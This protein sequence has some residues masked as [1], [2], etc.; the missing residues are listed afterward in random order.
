VISANQLKWRG[1][2]SNK[3]PFFKKKGGDTILGTTVNNTL[4]KGIKSMSTI[5]K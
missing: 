4:E 1:D 3:L 2:L 5:W